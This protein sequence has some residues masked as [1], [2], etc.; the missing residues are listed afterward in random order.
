MSSARSPALEVFFSYSHRD[1]TLRDELETHLALLKREGEIDTWHDR[2]IGAGREWKGEIDARLESADLI[3]LLIS[4]DFIAS[5]YCF[6]LEMTRALERHAAG[7]ARVIPIILRP[8]DWQTASFAKLQALPKGGKPITTWSDRDT[9]FVDVVN[10]LRAAIREL[11]RRRESN[12]SPAGAGSNPAPR[13][14]PRRRWT[15]AAALLVTVAVAGFLLIERDRHK[16][17]SGPP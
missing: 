14:T 8:T 1:E 6:D 9:A 3:L 2:R 5:D 15:A 7:D 13:T 16:E 10:G 12:P 17:P 11:H 4:P